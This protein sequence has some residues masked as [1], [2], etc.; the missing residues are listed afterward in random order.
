MREWLKFILALIV[1][2]ALLFALLVL[3]IYCRDRHEEAIL[4]GSA[5][6]G[7]VIHEHQ[8]DILA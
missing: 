6:L 1:C 7:A 2:V 5:S 8:H 3:A 4:P